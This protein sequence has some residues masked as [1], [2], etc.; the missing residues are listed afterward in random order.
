MYWKGIFGGL[1]EWLKK[2]D[3]VITLFYFEKNVQMLI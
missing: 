2:V 1:D 3:F